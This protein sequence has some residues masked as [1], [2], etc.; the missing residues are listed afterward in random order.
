LL[1]PPDH[2]TVASHLVA[3]QDVAQLVLIHVDTMWR[4]YELPA[5][6]LAFVFN[7][8]LETTLLDMSKP[9]SAWPSI[10]E[11]FQV[12]YQRWFHSGSRGGVAITR[13]R[14]AE[15]LD[16]IKQ[17]HFPFDADTTSDYV[18][19]SSFY[20][21][22]SDSH[23]EICALCCRLY[24]ISLLT[25][26][27]SRIVSGIGYVPIAAQTTRDPESVELL[28]HVGFASS[29]RRNVGEGR[30][31]A[32]ASESALGGM[33]AMIDG[34]A[35]S[36]LWSEDLWQG[37]ADDWRLFVDQELLMDEFDVISN[38]SASGDAAAALLAVKVPVQELFLDTLPA[39][40]VTLEVPASTSS[41]TAASN[42]DSM[43]DEASALAADATTATDSG[44][45]SVGI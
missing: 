31:D 7:F 39:M 4:R 28:L 32:T 8:H 15:I 43:V 23:P 34:A 22:V 9:C 3:S 26:N 40:T 24:A 17:N 27:V 20:S 44:V 42:G 13:A 41:A 10:T 5:M 1:T 14:I 25:A 37:F 2:F 38:E 6:L 16:T 19:V 11:Y 12:Y 33:E 30:G 29:M 21:F 36:V 35:D 18:D 45:I